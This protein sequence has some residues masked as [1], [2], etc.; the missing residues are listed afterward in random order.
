MEK[1]GSRVWGVLFTDQ[2]L[3]DLESTLA[4]YL[5]TG[6]IGK[7]LYCKQVDMDMRHYFRIVVEHTNPDHSKVELEIFVPHQYIKSVVAATERKTL[8]FV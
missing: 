6:R 5:S 8:G 1:P 4:P 7:Y 2:G 3:Q